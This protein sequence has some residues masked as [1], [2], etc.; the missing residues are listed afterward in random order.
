MSALEYSEEMQY[1]QRRSGVKPVLT[2]GRDIA[3]YGV[4]L[5]YTGMLPFLLT[6]QGA[7]IKSLRLGRHAFQR[8]SPLS[9]LSLMWIYIVFRLSSDIVCNTR[10]V[11]MFL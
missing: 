3:V 2:T 4:K 11:S 7:S 6:W 1:A 8:T 9:L 10:T 5:S